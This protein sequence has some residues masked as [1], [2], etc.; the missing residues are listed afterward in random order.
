MGSVKI[1]TSEVINTTMFLMICPEDIFPHPGK[2]HPGKSHP[3][4]CIYRQMSSEQ[5][6]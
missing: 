5:M 2:C 4:K 6:S 1:I 3:G